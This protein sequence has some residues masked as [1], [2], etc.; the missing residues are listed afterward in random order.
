VFTKDPSRIPQTVFLYLLLYEIDPW[1]HDLVHFS[2]LRSIKH[3]HVFWVLVHIDAVEDLLFY[4]PLREEL[5]EDGKV[6]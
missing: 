4:H 6:P 2:R 1:K 3:S 5:I